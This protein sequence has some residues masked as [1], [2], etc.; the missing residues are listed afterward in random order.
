MS[1]N[2]NQS[3]CEEQGH[4]PF[5]WWAFLDRAERGE[6]SVGS[7]E[8]T[9]A[10]LKAASWVTCVCGN[11][12]AAL[13]RIL[14]YSKYEGYPAD[15]ELGRLGMCFFTAIGDAD[16]HHAREIAHAI[17]ARTTVLLQEL[18]NPKADKPLA[19]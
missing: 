13:P 4:Q 6:I 18:N 17:E 5:D 15:V 9:S 10:M 8:H 7:Y 16:W 2:P 19:S 14:V 12:C 3:Y 11:Q 1:T